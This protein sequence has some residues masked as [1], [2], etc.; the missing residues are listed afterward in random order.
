MT[1]NPV[2]ANVLEAAKI[3]YPAINADSLLE[4]LVFGGSQGARI[5]SDIVPQAIALLTPEMRARI[6][7]TQQARPEDLE[8]VRDVY[9]Q[10]GVSAEIAPFFRDLPGRIARSH[11]V[12]SRSGARP[13]PELA[14][15]GRPAIL[16]PLPGALDQGPGSQCRVAFGCRRC[17]DASTNGIYATAS[18]AGAHLAS[19]PIRKA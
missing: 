10:N 11:L 8:R 7:I 2:R 4:L 5:M 14:V 13:F 12:I 9:A 6:R 17:P 3:P 1:G 15:I 16:V 19:G 18:G